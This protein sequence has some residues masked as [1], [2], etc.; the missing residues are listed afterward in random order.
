VKTPATS[1]KEI[2]GPIRDGVRNRR[3]GAQPQ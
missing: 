1:H 3:G 2:R